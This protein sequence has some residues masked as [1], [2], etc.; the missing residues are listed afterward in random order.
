MG[1]KFVSFILF[2]TILYASSYDNGIKY[3]KKK[4]YKKAQESFKI[5]VNNKDDRAMLALGIMYNN[6]DGVK[7]D[8]DIAINW[9]EKAAKLGNMYANE[10]LGN[11]YASKQDYKKAANFFEKA[12]NGG[13]ATSAYNLGYFYTGGLG[14]KRDLKKSLQWYEKSAKLGHIDAQLNL[15]FMYIAGHGT[16]VDYKKAAY[17]IKKAK[18]AGHPKADV[19]WKQF[20]LETYYKDGK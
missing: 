1:K 10:K 13:D 3:Y 17:W 9:Y 14:V 12:A 7:K 5:A 8:L 15:G 19:M 11:I 20:K 2:C 16:K 18:D 6:G 4:Q